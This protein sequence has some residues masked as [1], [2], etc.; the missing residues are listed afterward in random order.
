MITSGIIFIVGNF[1]KG[2]LSP[3]LL[4]SDVVLPAAM[5]SAIT[6][7]KPY[8]SIADGFFPIATLG[9]VIAVVVLVELALFAYKFIRWIYNKIPGVN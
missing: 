8:I 1:I 2:I 4:F 9:Q 7:F 5:T 3:L 6:S